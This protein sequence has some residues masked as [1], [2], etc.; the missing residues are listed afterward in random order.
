M[1]LILKT[2]KGFENMFGSALLGLLSKFPASY[3][4]AAMSSQV[5]FFN[6]KILRFYIT[7][8]IIELCVYKGLAGILPCIADI[9]ST[10]ISEKPKLNANIY[11]A[12]CLVTLVI[13]VVVYII[14]YKTVIL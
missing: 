4:N 3:T 14:L 8:N 9:I 13:G 2:N 11:F 10:S 1:L 5:S 6:S 7:N 12:I